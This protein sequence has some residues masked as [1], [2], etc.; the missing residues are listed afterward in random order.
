MMNGFVLD[1]LN[2]D[3]KQELL[4]IAN[5][6]PSFPG[7]LTMI[8]PADGSEHGEYL[9]AGNIMDL[10]MADV[11]ADGHDEIVGCAVNNA[12]NRAA[13]FCLD[14]GRIAGHS[15]NLPA[16]E[17]DNIP[18]ANERCYLLLPRT[19]VG[20][21]YR[22]V[23]DNNSA[24]TIAVE[25]CNRS[26]SVSVDDGA[27]IG[28]AVI[29]NFTFGFDLRIRHIAQGDTYDAMAS[30]LVRK[31]ILRS[32]PDRRYFERLQKT[33]RYWDGRRWSTTPVS[34]LQYGPLQA[35]ALLPALPR[36]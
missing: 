18:R 29:L 22:S 13:V 6:S 30:D 10:V 8:D 23:R 11:D 26:I 28:P 33:I 24:L 3:G 2:R 7:V 20:E 27:G 25:A 9:H 16:Y 4:L 14:G 32:V 35:A 21:S 34:P 12:F 36:K 1:D 31:G 15:P 17:P 19:V 5:H